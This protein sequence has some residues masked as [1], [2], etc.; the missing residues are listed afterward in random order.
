MNFPRDR[1]AK[2]IFDCVEAFSKKNSL[3]SS[4]LKK[5]FLVAFNLDQP[6]IK[7][8]QDVL[9]T[10]GAAS[11]T[12]SDKGKIRRAPSQ[13]FV[14]SGKQDFKLGD[15]ILEIKTGDITKATSDAIVVLGDKK[16]D[17]MGAVGNAIKN[18]EGGA[19]VKSIKR[20]SPQKEGTTKLLKTAM[21]PSKYVA[22]V[23]PASNSDSDL[24]EAIKTMFIKCDVKELASISLPAIGTGV[25][26]KRAEESAKLILH[27]FVELAVKKEINHIK[28]LQIVLYE[29]KLVSAFKKQIIDITKNPAGFSK[30]KGILKWIKEKV[31]VFTSYFAPSKEENIA[32]VADSY[33]P[34]AGSFK[35]FIWNLYSYEKKVQNEVLDRLTKFFDDMVVDFGLKN[36]LFKKL[37]GQAFNQIR[38][39]AEM[40]DVLVKLDSVAGE[41]NLVGYKSDTM[42]VT[43]HCQQIISTTIEEALKKDK[44]QTVAKY[45]QWK[46]K[47]KDESIYNYDPFLN[48]QIEEY[49]KESKNGVEIEME[50]DNGKICTYKLDFS[51]K[52]K[53][54]IVN[55]DTN[56]EKIIMREEL[57]SST[58][59]SRF[60]HHGFV[61]D[62]PH[63]YLQKCKA[64]SLG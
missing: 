57:P 22:H 46:E 54:K 5:V 52:E 18:A 19:W 42:L 47:Q 33:M 51:D 56:E 61:F 16:I 60:Y 63:C 12:T 55:K 3:R 32:D 2:I 24:R 8:F 44:E 23:F 21:L 45:V 27:S 26:G 17:L 48:C 15:V 14:D 13:S 36:E 37:P 30:D 49:Y 1:V 11:D 6:M 38:S 34:N 53:M 39:F 7:A 4:Q 58:S 10:R 9:A 28:Q 59:S 41:L 20:K 25:I 50:D 43:N 31:K 64:K 62:A 40:N 35:K 29:E